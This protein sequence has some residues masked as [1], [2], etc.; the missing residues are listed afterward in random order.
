MPTAALI[1]Q[2]PCVRKRLSATDED[3]VDGDVDW[4]IEV[5]F[6]AFMKLNGVDFGGRKALTQL[7]NVANNSHDQETHADGLGNAQE[8][9][10]VSCQRKVC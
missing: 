2:L 5:S 6:T 1:L 4:K 7:D 3:V 10:L 9:A 8:L